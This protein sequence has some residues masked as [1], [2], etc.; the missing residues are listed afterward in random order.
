MPL[1]IKD[2]H[3][4]QH[5]VRKR[6]TWIKLHHEVLNDRRFIRLPVSSRA[7]LPVLWLLA[8]EY[9]KGAIPLGIGD[10][11]FRLHWSEEAFTEAIRPC[12]DVGFVRWPEFGAPDCENGDD[13]LAPLS[14]GKHSSIPAIS[15]NRKQSKATDDS[16]SE[17]ESELER[18][19]HS[20]NG[21]PRI[22]QDWNPSEEGI[23]ALRTARPDLVGSRFVERMQ[24]FRDWC[25]AK[26]VTSHEPE[27]SWASFMRQTHKRAGG[28]G[29]P[30]MRENLEERSKAAIARS[31]KWEMDE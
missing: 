15:N 21:A 6:P 7:L 13:L 24:D 26:A 30:A 8:S 23:R 16:E 12:I 10:I 4:H 25:R 5:F 17:S 19:T 1:T 14:N 28:G 31:K 22:A 20:Q 27:A 9:D 3:K 2:W 11:A 29:K 18:E